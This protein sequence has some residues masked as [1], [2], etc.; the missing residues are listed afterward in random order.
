MFAAIVLAITLSATGGPA[1]SQTHEP[2]PDVVADVV[3]Q[4]QSLRRAV[5]EFVDEVVAPLDRR[6]P[7][8][9][10]R[11]VCV[12]VVNFQREAAQVLADQVSSVALEAGLDIGEPGCSPNVL[13]IATDDGSGLVRGLVAERPQAFR[14]PYA[15]APRHSAALQRFQDTSAPVRWWHIS[16][17]MIRDTNRPAVRMFGEGAPFIA[18]GNRLQ[19]PIRNDLQKVF[20]IV[21]V[22]AAEGVDI[23]RLG[24]Y[25]GMVA[26]SQIDPLA[27]TSTFDTVLNLFRDERHEVALTEWDRSY[28]HALYGAELNRRASNQQTGEIADSMLRDRQR[29]RDAAATEP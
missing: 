16:M 14:A 6:G 8:R 17:P 20:V 22:A 1:Q 4:G 29:N 18:G 28:L 2:P 15:G 24:D 23:R 21:D 27:E 10:N 7:A 5:E 19:N 13:I 3:V 9:W 11:S 26:L 12:G 25:V